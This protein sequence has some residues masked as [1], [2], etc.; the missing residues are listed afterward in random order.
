[1]NKQNNLHIIWNILSRPDNFFKGIA[2]RLPEPRSFIVSYG[3]PL[4]ILA[5][6]GRMTRIM[7]LKQIEETPLRGDQ[8]SG[9]FIITIIAYAFSVYLGAFIV[10]KLAPAFKSETDH[11]KSML[12]IILAYTPYLLAQAL[13]FIFPELSGG[14]V[15]GL[16]YT[17]LLFG[18]GASHLL[19]TPIQKVW[20][21]TLVSY[22]AIF[23][24]SYFSML[25][26]SELFIFAT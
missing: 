16:I 25:L 2:T 22:F 10:A 3:V 23:S 5:A 6:A 21:F 17:V 20:G 15:L 4:V 13:S 8:L 9:I 19:N 14:L 12:L 24:I 18:I 11:D 1:M 7:L 26:L